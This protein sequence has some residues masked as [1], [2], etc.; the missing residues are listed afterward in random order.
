MK[1]VP[2]TSV[3][4]IMSAC[5]VAL[6][7]CDSQVGSVEKAGK[8]IDNATESSGEQVEVAGVASHDAAQGNK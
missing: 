6:P 7:G 8:S 5:L 3:A 4:L 2:I 1:P